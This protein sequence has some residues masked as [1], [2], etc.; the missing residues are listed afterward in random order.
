MTSHQHANLFETRIKSSKNS[1]L[2]FVL[3]LLLRSIVSAQ[4]R[5]NAEGVGLLPALQPSEPSRTGNAPRDYSSICDL[6]AIA[7][8]RSAAAA[9]DFR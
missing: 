7:A 3:H 1:P 6:H 5:S 9:V 2:F 4:Y 8:E